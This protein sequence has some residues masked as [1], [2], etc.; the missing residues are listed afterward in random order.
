MVIDLFI[1]LDLIFLTQVESTTSSKY[2][3]GCL[4][5]LWC[6]PFQLPVSS[7]YLLLGFLL[8]S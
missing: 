1:S 6:T 5:R 8:G 3:F 2:S 4:L 7:E